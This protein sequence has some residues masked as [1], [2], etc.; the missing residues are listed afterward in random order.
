MPAR[1]LSVLFVVVLI[2]TGAIFLASC[3]S[4]NTTPQPNVP[5]TSLKLSLNTV[6]SGLSSP[7]DLEVSA[8]NIGRLFVVEQ[9]GTI[10]IISSEHRFE[11]LMQISNVDYRG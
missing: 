2:A 9:P 8:D 10:R 6:V 1:P 3:G 5:P 11:K 4:T 7:V